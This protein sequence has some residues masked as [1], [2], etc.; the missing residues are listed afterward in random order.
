ML[1]KRATRVRPPPPPPFNSGP[2][3]S[4][5]KSCKPTRAACSPREKT[6][7]TWIFA[8]IEVW[9]SLWTSTVV[10]R[11]SY[12]NTLA[13]VR[14]VASRMTFTTCPVIVTDG[15]EFYGKGIGGVFGPAAPYAQV[16]KTRG[17]NRVVRVDRR[18]V[19]GA[20]LDRNGLRPSR[21][22]RARRIPRR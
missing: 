17:H 10:G 19:I 18:T 5:P 9:S 11:R 15:F 14:D 13:L 22:S 2:P 8:G 3:A 16:L 20:V 7:P 4:S 12:Q 1:K 6:R 21:Y